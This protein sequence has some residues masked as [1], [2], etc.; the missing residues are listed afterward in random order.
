MNGDHPHP[1]GRTPAPQLEPL[2]QPLSKVFDA[3]RAAIPGT[4]YATMS[5]TFVLA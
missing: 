2:D 3:L 1:L 4:I 5:A